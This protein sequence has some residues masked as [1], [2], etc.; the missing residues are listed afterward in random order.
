MTIAAF[1]IACL[2]ALGT[3]GAVWYARRAVAEARRSADAAKDVA[4]IERARRADE[5]A[6]ADR[7]RVKFRL[8]HRTKD[9][10]VLRNAGTDSAYGVHVDTGGLGVPGEITH[11]DEFGADEEQPFILSRS[12]GQ[13]PVHVV[14]AWHMRP[15]RSDSPQTAKLLP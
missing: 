13:G 5:V 8:L 2:S 7:Q 14:V 15:D 10:Y 12:L 9:S 11:F 4:D 1:V 3:L 6:E